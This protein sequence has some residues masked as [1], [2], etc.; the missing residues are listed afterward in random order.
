[1]L[2]SINAPKAQLASNCSEM[3]GGGP[4]RLAK[5]PP[6]LFY[7][8]LLVLFIIIV[9]LLLPR[10]YSSTSNPSDTPGPKSNEIEVFSY[11]PT[12]P[13]TRPVCKSIHHH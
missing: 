13:L 7:L 2:E 6:R 9:I 4:I 10:K 11:N 3:A 5:I 12:Y 8:V 1:M